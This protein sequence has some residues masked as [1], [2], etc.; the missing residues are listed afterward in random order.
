MLEVAADLVKSGKI[1]FLEAS[2]RFHISRRTIKNKVKNKHNKKPGGQQKLTYSE[3]K[4]IV[5][6]LI[7]VVAFGA[8]LSRLDLSFV[9]F[10]YLKGNNKQHIFNNKPPG[11]CWLSNFLARH[12]DKLTT[13][14]AQNI[15][16]VR[17]AKTVDEFTIYFPN[18]KDTLKDIPAGNILNYDET[19]FSDNP[20][21][22]KCIF[23]REIKYPERVLNH[24]QGSISIMLASAAD[25]ILLAT[26]RYCL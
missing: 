12:K 15:K 9:V 11:K 18:L 20:G 8:P 22:S 5:N 24:T 7:A 17:A 1:S 21:S 16:K 4:Q 2:K 13:R 26:Y 10:H 25:G 19:N 14:A 23:K 3:E 6:V